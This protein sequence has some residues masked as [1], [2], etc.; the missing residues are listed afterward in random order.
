MHSKYSA[1]FRRITATIALTGLSIFVLLVAACAQNGDQAQTVPVVASA[2]PKTYHFTSDTLPAPFASPSVNNGQHI[3][4]HPDGAPLYAPL[5]FH[6]APWITHLDNPRFLT[7]A[8]NGDVFVS[9]SRANRVSVIRQNPQGVAA[10]APFATDMRQPFG[11]AFYPNGPNPQYIYIANTD[12]VVRYPYHNGDSSVDGPGE[13]IADL[14]GGGY[15]QHWTRTIVFSPDDKH[16]YIGCGS[17]E[18]LG[19]EDPPRAC[20]MECNPDGSGMQVFASGLRNAVGLSFN[21][22]SGELWAAVNERDGMGDKLP[23]DYATSVQRGGFY[24]WPY[25]YIGNHPDPRLPTPANMQPPIVP[26]VLLEA[27][28]AA[29]SVEFYE[30]T[31]FPRSYRGDA[32]VAMHGS[33]NRADPSGYKVVRVPMDS[34]GHTK[35]GY[36]DFVWGWKTSDGQVWGRP[37]AIAFTRDGSMLLTDDGSNTIWKITYS[38][39]DTSS[40]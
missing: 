4:D 28:C 38:A 21:P 34:H 16:L 3:V 5:G 20:I 24:G 37:V 27:H 2:S 17:R 15:N 9:E 31:Q 18:N 14:P 1:A 25:V 11:I 40:Q 22:K 32:F 36:Q 29:L 26:D 19:V 12:S 30:G 35:G 6:V 33:W 39:S 7:V 10:A 13:K 8:P 23:P